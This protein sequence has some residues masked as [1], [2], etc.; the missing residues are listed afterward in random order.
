MVSLL[1]YRYIID[2][3]LLFH[4]MGRIKSCGFLRV[5]VILG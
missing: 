4:D 5:L 1:E 2:K 3:Q